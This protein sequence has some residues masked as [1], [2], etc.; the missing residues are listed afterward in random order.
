MEDI[1][2]LPLQIQKRIVRSSDCQ[3]IVAIRSHRLLWDSWRRPSKNIRALFGDFSP[4]L[5]VLQPR[6]PRHAVV[7]NEQLPA[8]PIAH[9]CKLPRSSDSFGSNLLALRLAGLRFQVHR[10]LFR[11]L[12]LV[13]PMGRSLRHEI[14]RLAIEGVLLFR[15]HSRTLGRHETAWRRLPQFQQPGWVDPKLAP[16]SPQVVCYQE[17]RK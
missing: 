4:L 17:L 16:P 13:A 11:L 2:D 15:G 8:A 10:W 9:A 14:L 7:N 6:L 3:E 12:A 5:E 1:Y